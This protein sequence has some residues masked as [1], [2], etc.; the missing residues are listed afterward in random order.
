[1]PVAPGAMVP[2]VKVPAEGVKVQP[3]KPAG[4]DST[5]EKVLLDAMALGPALL[6]VRV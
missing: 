5:I 4:R 2:T 3:V 1:V 6:T